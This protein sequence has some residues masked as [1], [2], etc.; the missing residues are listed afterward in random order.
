MIGHT[1]DIFIVIWGQTFTDM[2]LV[3]E[4]N[5]WY[6]CHVNIHNGISQTE[7]EIDY[8]CFHWK[9]KAKAYQGISNVYGSETFVIS[10]WCK[11]MMNGE[12]FIGKGQFEGGEPGWKF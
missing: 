12:S 8:H 5:K 7:M 3:S 1:F 9:I 11:N 6:S 2:M 10:I 4:C